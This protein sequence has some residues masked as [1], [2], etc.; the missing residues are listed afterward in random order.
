[1]YTT[2]GLLKE[3]MKVLSCHHQKVTMKTT[4]CWGW[5]FGFIFAL[6]VP[7]L[8][9]SQE[10]ALRAAAP[11]WQAKNRSAHQTEWSSVRYRTNAGTGK[12]TANTNSYIELASGLNYLDPATQKWV[13]SKEEI[14]IVQGGAIARQGQHSVSFSANVNTAGGIQTTAA[15]GK[16][17]RSHVL[18]LAYTDAASGQSVLIAGV[19]DSIGEVAGNQVIYRDAFDGPFKA[20]LRY[21]YTKAGFE[22]DVI[23]REAPPSPEK[24]G[25]DPETT[26]V[27]VWTEFLQPPQP[28][29]TDAVLK[30]ESD[31][32]VRSAMVDPD[33]TDETLDFGAM[34]IGAGIA[35]SLDEGV[36]AVEQKS[37]PVGKNWIRL[38]GRDFLIEKVDFEDALPGL[39][40]LPQAPEAQPVDG[41]KQASLPA[42]PRHQLLTALKAPLH[43][44]DQAQAPSKP[45]KMALA[46]PPERGFVLD[47]S[48]VSSQ[49]NMVFKGHETYHVTAA[50]N[51]TGTTVIEGGTVV[52]FNNT[53]T[54]FTFSG[55]IICRTE[56][57]RPAYFTARDDNSV[58]QIVPGSTGV[59]SGY[60]AAFIFFLSDATTSYDFHNLRLRYASD[61]IYRS[62]PNSGAATIT[63][64]HSQVQDCYRAFANSY[65]PL[66]LRN[67]L[68]YRTRIGYYSTAVN[69]GENVTFHNIGQLVTGPSQPPLQLKNTLLISCTNN[70]TAGVA[71]VADPT[72]IKPTTSSDAGI[73]QTSGL[74]RHYLA[75]STYRGIG[76]PNINATL[77]SDLKQTTTW[78]PEILTG[79]LTA[80]RVLAPNTAVPRNSTTTPPDLGYSYSVMDYVSQNLVVQ[81]NVNQTVTLMIING[82]VVGMDPT[83][84]PANVG[85]NG[86]QFGTYSELISVGA[87]D[88]LN[89]LLP[90]Q[91]VQE[92]G[93]GSATWPG[94]F[95]TL[96]GAS[97]GSYP[98]ARLRFTDL[99]LFAG[100]AYHHI[101]NWN[102]G[103]VK[104]AIQDSQIRGGTLNGLYF[105]SDI[106]N[107]SIAL[108][109]TLFENVEI[110]HHPYAFGSFHARNNLFKGGALR[111]DMTP[112]GTLNWT[113]YDNLF[114]GTAISQVG[115]PNV[116]NNYN[117]YVTAQTSTR[118]TPA[119]A[120][121]NN[122]DQIL[123]ASPAY[124]IGPFGNNYLQGLPASLINQGSRTAAAAGLFHYTTSKTAATKEGSTQVDI[125]LHY[126][127]PNTSS[128][129]T[130][131]DGDSLADYFEDIDG[132][133]IHDA[134]ETDWQTHTLT[135]AIL[136]ASRRIVWEPGVPGG[137]PNRTTEHI[138]IADTT[139]VINAQPAIQAA[140][141]ACPP[142]EVV[143]LPPGTYR[144][145]YH[146]TMKTDITLRGAGPR[147]AVTSPTVLEYHRPE[148]FDPTLGVGLTRGPVV[149]RFKD[150]SFSAPIDSSAVPV[151]LIGGYSKGST[152]VS[153]ANNSWQIG[154]VIL[155]DAK[156]DN[157]L[158]DADGNTSRCTWCGRFAKDSENNP[159][160]DT[161]RSHNQLVEIV[162]R[163]P[164]SITFWPPLHSDYTSAT[165]PEGVKLGNMI[166]NAGLENL[167]ITNVVGATYT[168]DFQ[169]AYKCWIKNC[170]LAVSKSRHVWM[171]ASLWCEFRD[172]SF[173]H[174]LGPDWSTPAYDPGRGYG[175]FLGYGS[176]ACL[177]E[178]NDFWKL[179]FPV[180][181]EGGSSGNV[182]AY[183]FMADIMNSAVATPKWTIGNHAS[184]PM[185]NL[186]E[187]NILRSKVVLD[188]YFGTSSHNTLFRNRISNMA[189]N[190]CVPPEQYA[191]VVDIWKKHRYQNII[192]NV[193]GT[194][195]ME[196]SVN[197]TPDPFLQAAKF[198]YR[199]GYTDAN[200][201]DLAGNDTTVASTIIRHGN[202]DS[203][204]QGALWEAGISEHNLPPSLYRG[205]KPAWWVNPQNQQDLPWPAI[206][207]DLN[208]IEGQIPAQQ[209]HYSINPA[210]TAPTI[211]GIA[212]T[213]TSPNVPTPAIPFT[214]GDAETA[215]AMLTLIPSS[216]NTDLVPDANIVFGGS[217]ADRTVTITPAAGQ[218]G[219]TTITLVV[220]D[221]FAF[222]MDSF[223]LTVVEPPL[224]SETF[225]GP[226]FS[227]T[228]WT[229]TGSPNPDYTTT[230]LDGDQSLNCVGAQ[231]IA[232]AFEYSTSFN[233]YF[234]V[235]WNTL[236][237]GNRS[238]VYWQAP[239]PSGDTVASVRILDGG[240]VIQI[241]HGGGP[242]T[243]AYGTTVL[244]VNQ[245]YHVWIEWAKGT[246]NNGTM[247]LFVSTTGIKPAA[248]ANINTGNGGATGTIFVGPTAAG[249][250]VIY[251]R[252]IISGLQIG[253]QDQ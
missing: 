158:I 24:F 41:E 101:A 58:G 26:R 253:N 107:H 235:R 60:Y 1:M 234:R 91:T 198:I 64:R 27:E 40:K 115:G 51:F 178:N 118:L 167:S 221:G 212:D 129:P 252:L 84:G 177:V 119:V 108:T 5:V 61:A 135:E 207:S 180:A 81:G 191:Y 186:W 34:R 204:T 111:F 248:Q 196:T 163:T 49:P 160:P 232:H 85:R 147:G 228:G 149:V 97:S 47:Y 126:A 123:T 43:E 151:S 199:L 159:V 226:G 29:K 188:S 8:A 90:I 121:P 20:D 122:H 79:T 82:A 120:I 73:F 44:K 39:Q 140:I 77:L 164:S 205:G 189:R 25:F 109:N 200:D 241:V 162:S 202:W 222:A 213:A 240:S 141:N 68:V 69:F 194:V 174:G 28:L 145:N 88:K 114:D 218:I 13:E 251:D 57:Y 48:L 76:T 125:G 143:L 21:T 75:T 131:T 70:S 80:N 54:Y 116:E 157:D 87:P 242:N 247:K 96:H 195:G 7:P 154:D 211:T 187:G 78:P 18:G 214:I 74:G 130:D 217:G 52:K 244:A 137:I 35:F 146:L 112:P 36:D 2:A 250:N 201:Q 134:G 98:S 229:L 209:R 17:L 184:H 156:E 176:T 46:V 215:A 192:G 169:G 113:L 238:I 65:S 71:Y 53:G 173:H 144:L 185:M 203:V 219:S 182:I 190:R 37:I 86:I 32:L 172:S 136:P 89:R 138:V 67:V 30:T 45:M 23:F 155:I 104:L 148:Y 103:F 231:Y 94:S 3:Q 193:L 117:A 208:P 236:S 246:G 181:F 142:N 31:A 245:T 11:Q 99:T 197:P 95:N 4:G 206:G 62:A 175:I 139:G 16:I 249:P 237:T 170:E 239:A 92:N 168:T 66:T 153:T 124:E 243:F 128:Q 179:S 50:A 105:G 225:E 14:E 56:P 223:V 38:E 12:I 210:N 161:I 63:V 93:P 150:P 102:G 19:R 133:G 183:N 55:G 33:L 6:T 83:V 59:P 216:S 127:A 110:T 230:A 42:K 152:T 220:C 166:K 227:S 9:R 224:T 106:L 100:T 165:M 233:M 10:S 171:I 15:D 22:Q 132:D 72:V